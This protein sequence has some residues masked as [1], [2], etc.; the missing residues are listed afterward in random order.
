MFRLLKFC[1]FDYLKFDQLI[2]VVVIFKITT[3]KH[4]CKM[5]VRN[6]RSIHEPNLGLIG[7][8]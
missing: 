5:R 3:K 1:C 2:I 7:L 4:N 6:I 8:M